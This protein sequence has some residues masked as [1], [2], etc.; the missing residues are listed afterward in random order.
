M[1]GRVQ[2]LRQHAVIGRF[3]AQ[4]AA[5]TLAQFVHA[6]RTA[7]VERVHDQH[8]VFHRQPHQEMAGEGNAFQRQAEP[9]RDLDLHQGQRDRV[10]QAALEHLV[11]VAVARVVVLVVVAAVTDLVEQ[12]VVDGGHLERPFADGVHFHPQ[13]VGVGL[14]HAVVLGRVQLRVF[15]AGD[16]Q[17]GRQQRQRLV[18]QAGQFIPLRQGNARFRHGPRLAAKRRRFKGA[19]VQLGL[20]AQL[21]VGMPGPKV[22][23]APSCSLSLAAWPALSSST[24]R[25]G[26]KLG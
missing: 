9:A 3:T 22:S 8:A 14:Q 21:P 13:V 16:Q 26:L 11:E 15:V 24:Y 23:S 6:Q 10:A 12:V 20:A 7:A 2:D 25:A 4:V 18:G 19:A 1:R 5:G 17:G